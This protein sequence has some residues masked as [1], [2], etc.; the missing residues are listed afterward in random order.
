[1]TPSRSL[2]RFDEDRIVSAATG[3]MI[4][5]DFDGVIADSEP[6]QG[7]SYRAL[8]ADMGNDVGDFRFDRYV[9]RT[10]REVWEMIDRDGYRLQSSIAELVRAREEIYVQAALS[11]LQPT[12]LFRRVSEL[13]DGIS[14]KQVVVSNGDPGIIQTL[15]EHWR[16]S[17]LEQLDPHGFPGGKQGLLSHLW[18]SGPTVT[19]EDNAVWLKLAGEAGSWRVAVHHSLNTAVDLEGEL[20]VS[21]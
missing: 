12:W 3:S 4:I 20:E 5:W 10:E 9:S 16:V 13:V 21:L 15:L 7:E 11:R 8:L 6:L 19:I 1:M 2:S 18:S 14:S 17:S